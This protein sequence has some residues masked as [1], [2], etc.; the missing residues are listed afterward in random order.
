MFVRGDGMS[1][2]TIAPTSFCIYYHVPS[3]M[4]SCTKQYGD[5]SPWPFKIVG[6]EKETDTGSMQS[7]LKSYRFAAVSQRNYVVWKRVLEA[8]Q[9]RLDLE[10]NDS[11]EVL[12][13]EAGNRIQEQRGRVELDHDDEDL[14]EGINRIRLQEQQDFEYAME[15]SRQLNGEAIEEEEEE[16]EQPE[17]QDDEEEEESIR[18]SAPDHPDECVVCL[19]EPK[20][21][22][23]IP[24]GHM[25]CF[26]CACNLSEC[27]I[28]RDII[29]DVL[30]VYH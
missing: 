18:P 17:Y 30:K 15:L 20:N 26:D 29:E 1:I 7:S 23:L 9:E 2:R 27:P 11:E 22:A 14:I 5:K 24:C 6:R 28:C 10:N 16:Q 13:E 21:C 25:L 19:D 4:Q 8:A 12:I 3:G